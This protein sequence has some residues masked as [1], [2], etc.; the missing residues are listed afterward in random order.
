MVDDT[1][2][3]N[4]TSFSQTYS[5]STLMLLVK[6]NNERH[7]NRRTANLYGTQ[8]IFAIIKPNTL[9]ESSQY[10]LSLETREVLGCNMLNIRR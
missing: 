7:A 3:L 5:S 6:V 10:L 4:L 9:S 2:Y 1:P 8:Y